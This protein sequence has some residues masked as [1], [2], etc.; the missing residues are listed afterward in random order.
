MQ[1]MCSKWVDAAMQVR[2]G[3][4]VGCAGVGG[5]VWG[6]GEGKGKREGWG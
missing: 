1:V 2:G 5:G 6:G 4:G 3:S